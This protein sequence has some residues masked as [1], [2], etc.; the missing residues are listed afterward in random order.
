MTPFILFILK[1]SISLALV[2]LFYRLLLRRLTFYNS[3]RWYLLAYTFLCFIIPFVD[4][5]PFVDANHTEPTGIVRLIPAIASYATESGH[6][7]DASTAVSVWDLWTWMTL[8]AI[9]GAILLLIRFSLFVFSYLQLRRHA[10]LLSSDEMKLYHVNKSIIPFSFGNAVFINKDLHSETE[11]AE[12]IRHEFVH[13][14][15]RH[16]IDIVWAELLCMLS[17]YNPFAWLLRAAIRQNLEFIADNE[18]LQHGIQKKTYQYLLLRVMGNDQY[19]IAQKFNFSSLKKR[20]AMMNKLKTT[21]VHLL[22]FLFI[23]PLLAVILVSFR[24]KKQE[25]NGIHDTVASTTQVLRDT[26]PGLNQPNEKGYIVNVSGRGG[27]A[28][29]VVKDKNGKLVER[30]PFKKWQSDDSYAN[31]YGEIPPPPPPP[32]PLAP[33]TPPAPPVPVELPDGIIRIDVK[34]KKATVLLKDGSEEKYNLSIPEEK[35]KFEKKY[36]DIIPP[37]PVPPAK[38]VGA[39]EISATQEINRSR[40]ASDMEITDDHKAHMRLKDGTIEEY[41]LSDPKQKKKFET[42]YGKLVEVPAP[43]ADDVSSESMTIVRDN[44]VLAPSLVRTPSVNV[45]EGNTILAP[46]HADGVV[47]ID[48]GGRI[49]PDREEEV[50]MTVTKKNT[51]EQLET[52]VQQMKDRGITLKFEKTNYNN[53]VLVHVEGTIIY[54]DNKSNFSATDFNKLILSVTKDEGRGFLHIRVVDNKTVI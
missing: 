19:S 54:Q 45:V 39:Y 13:V 31:K 9:G 32:P 25:R 17:W 41:D 36:G 40:V 35:A 5:S 1:S 23:V 4:I 51:K 30:V 3:N 21:R 15:Q 26:I 38:P 22:R 14:K 37:P 47:T 27:D 46:T 50:L 2:Y 11:L 44:V 7:P 16:T 18:V 29:V 52:F 48:D 49:I 10:S 8:I 42:K 6:D 12:I 24:Q 53:G 34:D 43:V 20:I 33:P 28:T